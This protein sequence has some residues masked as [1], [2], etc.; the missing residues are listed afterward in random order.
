MWC[1]LFNYGFVNVCYIQAKF[2]KYT[3][4]EKFRKTE[5][6]LA[7][8]LEES[9]LFSF[10]SC[11]DK[12]EQKYIVATLQSVYIHKGSRFHSLWVSHKTREQIPLIFH[13]GVIWQLQKWDNNTIYMKYSQNSKACPGFWNSKISPFAS[14]AQMQFYALSNYHWHTL[15]TFF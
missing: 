1:L 3:V 6:K 4:Q 11:P 7:E 13:R 8:A 14:Y 5:G 9:G 10:V 15:A 2:N 12:K